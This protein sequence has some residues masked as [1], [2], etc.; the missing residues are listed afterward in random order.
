M[1]TRAIVGALALFGSSVVFGCQVITQ[2]N[3][4]QVTGTGGADGGSSGSGTGAAG[5]SSSSGTGAAADSGACTV[6]EPCKSMGAA[7]V[8][9]QPPDG[10]TMCAPCGA[11]P[12]PMPTCPAGASCAYCD[13]GTC[14]QTCD[15]GCQTTTLDA[16]NSP[17]QLVCNGMGSCS[18]MTIECNGPFPCEVECNGGCENLT[19]K[20]DTAGPCTL[21][22]GD[23]SCLDAGVICGNNSCSVT[24]TQ[25]GPG[26]VTCGNSCSCTGKPT[27]GG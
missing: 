22:C 12:T 25:M 18:N 20:C 26:S 6:N 7:G 15:G 9:V 2:L 23:M 11:T 13:A 17:V 5:S 21:A 16:T 27:C 19:L 4:L 14:V 3:V 24:C 10:G 1:R 8:C